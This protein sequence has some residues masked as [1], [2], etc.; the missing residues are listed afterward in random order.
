MMISE[1]ENGEM[2]IPNLHDRSRLNKLSMIAPTEYLTFTSDF[3][4]NQ[5]IIQTS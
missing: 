3:I 4:C 2:D 1:E 5:P